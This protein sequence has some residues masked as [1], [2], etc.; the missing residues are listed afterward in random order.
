MGWWRV[1]RPVYCQLAEHVEKGP[2]GRFE[3]WA[4]QFL[5][6]SYNVS[7]LPAARNHFLLDQ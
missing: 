6:L 3:V 1:S 2:D 7:K 4:G 5:R